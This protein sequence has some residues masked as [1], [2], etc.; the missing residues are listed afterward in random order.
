VTLHQPREELFTWNRDRILG[1]TCTG[2]F[3][4]ETGICEAGL[5]FFLRSCSA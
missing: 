1:S 3:D 5:A 2:D 4:C